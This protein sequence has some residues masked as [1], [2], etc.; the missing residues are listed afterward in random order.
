MKLL[1]FLSVLASAISVAVAAPAPHVTLKKLDDRVRVEVGGQLFT[2]YVFKGA[3]RPYCYPILAADGTS[4]VRDFPMKETAGEET[5]HKHHRALMFAHSNVNAVDFWNEGTSGTKFPKGD[6]VHDGFVETTSGA[7]GVLRVRNRWVAPDG[8]LMATD[9]TTLRFRG[10]GDARM[11]D[12]DVTIQARPDAP[13]VMGDN[14]DGTM[15]IR[16]AQ[17]MTMPHK[18][19]KQDVPGAGHIVTARGDRDAAAW[20][21]RAE[22]CDYFAARNGKTYGIAIFDHPQNVRHPTWWMARD[23]GL[24]AANPFGQKDFEVAAKHPPGKGDYTIPAGGTLTLRYRFYFHSGDEKAAN[25]AGRYA[26]Y[27]AGR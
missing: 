20:G 14:K 16:I 10:E 2:E 1:P 27:A 19:L 22:W 6:T 23:Y 15:A 18:Y 26:D 11:L 9:E 5:D 12:Y 8:R 17:W 3:S 21:T 7:V 13:L 24:F 4:L 25:V